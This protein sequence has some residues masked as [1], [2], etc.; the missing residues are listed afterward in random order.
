MSQHYSSYSGQIAPSMG[1]SEQNSPQNL[2][3]GHSSMDDNVSA[4]ANGA[5]EDMQP[6]GRAGDNT[7][8]ET[9]AN[10]NGDGPLKRESNEEADTVVPTDDKNPVNLE[11]SSNEEI[12]M[13]E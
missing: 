6:E 12:K 13:E 7:P 2:V 11:S 10:Q 8:T 9:L 5:H 3:S 4:L 1:A